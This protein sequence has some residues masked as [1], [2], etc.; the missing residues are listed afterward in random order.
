MTREY[1]AGR[2]ARYLS[3]VRLYLIVSVTAIGTGLLADATSLFTAVTT[4]GATIAA[5]AA[6]A[7]AWH[8]VSPDA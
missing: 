3:P 7:I 6:A 4:T 1:I 8:V 2:R 5:L